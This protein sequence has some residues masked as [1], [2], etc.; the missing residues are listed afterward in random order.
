MKVLMMSDMKGISR[1]IVPV[2]GIVVDGDL[3]GTTLFTSRCWS[4]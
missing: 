3:S 2:E 1:A 4:A